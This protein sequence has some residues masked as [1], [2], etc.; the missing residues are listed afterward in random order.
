M[1]SWLEQITAIKVKEIYEGDLV[2]SCAQAEQQRPRPLEPARPV[3]LEHG[4]NSG[5]PPATSREATSMWDP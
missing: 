4:S 3:Q 5:V 1:W 2:M